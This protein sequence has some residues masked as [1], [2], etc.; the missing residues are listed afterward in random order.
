NAPLIRIGLINVKNAVVPTNILLVDTH[1][2]IAD[3]I[4]RRILTGEFMNFYAGK[5]LLPLRLHYK[6]YSEWQNQTK[7][8]ERVKKQETYWLKQFD[9]EIPV[10]NLPV[11]Y[12]RSAIRSFE[13]KTFFFRL[14]EEETV[15]LKKIALAHGATLYMILL[16]IFNSFLSMLS[17]QED[18][19][20][21]TPTA[22]RGHAN[23][24]DIIGMFVNTLGL[25]NQPHGDKTYEEFLNNVKET[26]L[27]AFD[28][29]DYQFEELVE[30]LNISRDASRNP[31]FDVM[32]LLQNM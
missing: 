1:H 12:P 23:L 6:D 8:K 24:G 21:G 16:T 13:G 30:T 14:N 19:I 29:Q 28:N 25:R 22:G 27:N 15:A 9:E 32:F 2:T 7:E 10:L 31:L 11:D 18:I 5:E 4:S 20:I 3:G 17:G 26:T